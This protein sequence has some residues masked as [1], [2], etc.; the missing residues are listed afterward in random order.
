MKALFVMPYN[1]DLIHAVSLPL[2]LISIGSYL[3]ENGYEVRICD[4][5]VS[6]INIEKV[7]DEFRPDVVGISLSSV[8]HIEGA[9]EVSKKLHKKGVPIVWG[10]T[11]CDVCDPQIVFDGA[12]ADYLSFCEGEATWL[13]IM[14][15]LENGGDLRKLKGIAYRDDNGKA[16]V[17]A[18][19][20][21]VDL[22]KLPL[23]DYTLVDVKAY[24][25]Y[26]YGC[27]NLVYVYL[28]KG[29]PSKCTFCVNQVTHRCT[30]RRR[31]LEHFM[32]ETEILVK[33]YGVDG[34]YF[35]D[36]LCFKNKEQ[37]YEVCDAFEKSGLKFFWGFQTR[38]GI[39]GEEEFRRCY[40][41]GCRWV[42]FGIESGSK[43]QLAIMKKG[44]PYEKIEPTFE[45]CDKLGI[46][47]LANFIVGL[48]G[49]TEEQLMET[50]NLA[51]RIKATQC[52]FLQ[53]CISPNTVMS[54]KAIDDGLVKNPVRKLKDYRKIDFFLSRT[55]NLSKIRQTE[56]NVVQSYYL[57]NA[58]FKK[59]YGKD[60][61]SYDLL[62]KHM[63]TLFHRLSFLSFSNGVKCLFEFG[64]LGLRFFTDTHFHPGI[65]KKYNLKK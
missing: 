35:C 17:T 45:I 34:L 7:F 32:K 49:E 20:E 2:G 25:Q 23:L 30:Y 44:I 9:T 55:D 38:I 64:Y 10:G 51:N 21:F 31:E 6:H 54:Q 57:W 47:S 22:T 36:E 19:R 37:V 3:Q 18:Q 52:S 5:S 40:E 15:T 39:L 48:P 59:D 58:V 27:S 63:Q 60:A 13:E 56:L 4:M 8:K 46:I 53:Y 65:I 24:S 43:E 33:Q 11:F 42:D 16:V 26:L 28:S 12:D 62:F 14:Q 41:C 50:V 29:C 61:K 1:C